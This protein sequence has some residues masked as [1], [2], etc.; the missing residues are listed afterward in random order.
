[1]VTSRVFCL[2]ER[3]ARAA[4]PA[5]INMP[6]P[7]SLWEMDFGIKAISPAS[8]DWFREAAPPHRTSAAGS[9]PSADPSLVFFRKGVGAAPGQGVARCQRGLASFCVRTRSCER[10]LVLPAVPAQ[11]EGPGLDLAN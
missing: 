1:M 6:H 2:E 5:G 7:R 11:P 9:G 4:G 3:A 10:L 8:S